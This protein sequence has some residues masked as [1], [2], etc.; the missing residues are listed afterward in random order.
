MKGCAVSSPTSDDESADAPGIEPRRGYCVPRGLTAAGSLTYDHQIREIS[1][2]LTQELE[3]QAHRCHRT[4]PVLTA[5]DVHEAVRAWKQR[6]GEQVSDDGS[7][8]DRGVAAALLLTIATVGI[9]VMSHFLHSEWQVGTFVVFVLIG[10]VGLVL[11]WR[12]RPQLRRRTS[13]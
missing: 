4:D 9:T 13:G 11:T 7:D 6:I 2:A 12:S 10:V 1:A 3:I 5:D 8:P